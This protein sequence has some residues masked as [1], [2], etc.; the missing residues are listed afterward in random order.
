MSLPIS[1]QRRGDAEEE[2]PAPAPAL[3]NAQI[4]QLT[5]EILA[6]Q[7]EQIEM[8]VT[9]RFA[10]GLYLRE[11]FMPAGTFVIGNEHNSEHF[12]IVTEG[13]ANV[14]MTGGEIA[15]TIMA[16]ACFK[17]RPGVRKVLYIL[18]DMRFIT[19]H[20]NPDDCQDVVALEERLFNL[21]PDL[22]A[23]KGN[24]PIDDWRMSLNQ[25]PETLKSRGS[26]ISDSQPLSISA[27]PN[28]S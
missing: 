14:L 18:E 4:E 1:T 13:M 28:P 3:S 26:E 27:S 11:I 20:A 7:H 16:P 23:A 15:E 5:Q 8:P 25:K 12:N 10:P 17:T 9:H 2:V 22:L 21:S 6:G 24:R 19:V